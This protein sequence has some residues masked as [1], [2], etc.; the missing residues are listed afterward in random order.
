M[1][2][3]GAPLRL[4]RGIWTA[5]EPDAAAGEL[6]RSALDAARAVLAAD[7]C[8]FV[9]QP[10][11]GQPLVVASQG[12]SE[13]GARERGAAW[14]AT[15]GVVTGDAAPVVTS[16]ELRIE[17]VPDTGG[18]VRGAF[19]AALRGDHAHSPDA[20]MLMPVFALHLGLLTERSAAQALRTESYEALVQ[21][22][23][24]IQAEE[25]DVDRALEVIV[26]RARDLMGTDLAWIAMVDPE[27]HAIRTA[28]AIGARTQAF[29][30]L[31]GR[32]EESVGGVVVATGKPVALPDYRRETLPSA[33]HIRAVLLGEGI[34]SLL[35][36]PMLHGEHVIGALYV[37]S[38][39]PMDFSATA[40]ALLSALA[41][42]AAVAVDNGRLYAQLQD[43]NRV[44][45]SAFTIHR[46]LTDA[47]LAGSGPHEICSRLAGLIGLELS[48]EQE[49]CSPFHVRCAPDGAVVEVEADAP[50]DG[51]LTFPVV[52][53]VEL[54][55]LRVAGVAALTALQEKA[56]EH[57]ATV[58]GLE[59]LKQRTAQE[60]AWQLQ[61]DLLNELLDA[62]TPPS[63]T[64]VARARRHGVDLA[65][66]RYVLAI[67][68]AGGEQPET[69]AEELLALV[70]RAAGRSALDGDAA[71][72]TLRGRHVILAAG[73]HREDAACA[74]LIQAITAAVERRG[75]V[76]AVG[77]G[78]LGADLRLAHRQAIACASL[79][80]GAGAA[81]RVLHAER[82]GPLRFVLDAAD[83]THVR[84][85]VRGQLG[86]LAARDGDSR[87]ELFVTLRAFVTA[88][89]NVAEAAE[90]CYVHKNTLR[91]RLRRAG[92]ILGR[93]PFDPSVRFDLRIAF[94][95]L[96]VFESL[97]VDLL[98]P[99][100]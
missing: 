41:A 8:A 2:S 91:Y 54:G 23:M 33:P 72:V 88:D 19:V 9:W 5:V 29:L 86:E 38:R 22:G 71:L 46:A 37:G 15:V 42:Q 7:F 77:V 100:G 63:A 47:A 83:P 73:D 43:Q 74:S 52:G 81:T 48:L 18:R 45:E 94:G 89:G 34:G 24:Q 99:A 80:G 90:A 76:V 62:P 68:P 78:E 66:P 3:D 98:A 26:Q 50:A 10:P 16:P 39:H 28:V 65:R 13:A 4:A 96:E 59:L 79:A 17:P 40:I 56:V 53:G 11:S 6:A 57:G 36:A 20:R 55:R 58:V 51:E 61:G 97:G 87:A 75:G 44:L 64:L 27:A 14:L 25:I 92:E 49:V 69:D 93:D 60:V 84:T 32:L 82:L 70:R 1:S 35:C 67:T 95:L 31:V 21:I 85:I 12:I 30:K